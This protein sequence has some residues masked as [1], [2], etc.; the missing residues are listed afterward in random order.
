[1]RT[2]EEIKD[3]IKLMHSGILSGMG[4]RSCII[5]VSSALYM[6]EK[7]IDWIDEEERNDGDILRE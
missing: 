6:L 4:R 1:M 3:R 5:S 2:A 7:L